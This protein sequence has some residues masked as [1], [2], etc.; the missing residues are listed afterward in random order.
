MVGLN[1]V[2][3]IGRLGKDPELRTTTTGRKVCTFNIAVNRRWRSESGDSK[4]ATDWLLVETWGRLAEICKQYLKKGR[5]VY[6]EGRLR[7]D[8][9]ELEGEGRYHTRVIASQMQML[10]RRM[11]EAEPVSEEE[12]EGE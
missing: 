6:L 7:T 9:Y 4:E 2:Q 11:E 5:M 3:L 1:R 12:P 8:R 10:D